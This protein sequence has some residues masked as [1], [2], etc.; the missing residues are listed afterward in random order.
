MGGTLRPEPELLVSVELPEPLELEVP[1][2]PDV[3][4]VPEV[5]DVPDVLELLGVVV[6]VVVLGLEL[7]LGL[8]VLVPD[9]PLLLVSE[10]PD[11]PEVLLF[12][13]STVVVVV[14]TG[15][16]VPLPDAPLLEVPAPDDVA[17]AFEGSV[18]T[19]VVVV[20]CPKAMVAVP[21][22]EIKMAIGNFFM[23]APFF[24]RMNS[25]E[26]AEG[27]PARTGSG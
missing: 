8:V 9:A 5:S 19:V 2:V 7:L 16:D 4:E 27:K 15:A 20:V 18:V 25:S 17:S 14:V 23:L 1:D 10:E 22:S 13:V 6:E 26:T 11:E 3:P 24:K 21:I 12:G